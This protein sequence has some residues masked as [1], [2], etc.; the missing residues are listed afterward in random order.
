MTPHE[1]AWE[2][3]SLALEDLYVARA[4]A[5]DPN[6]PDRAVGYNLQQAVEKLLKALLAELNLDYPR[7]HSLRRLTGL[8]TEHG[9]TLPGFVQELGFLTRYAVVERYTIRPSPTLDRAKVLSLV[10][11]LRDWVENELA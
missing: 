5:P 1:H 9:Y 3:V 8:V 10:E 4:I 11:Q 7:T 2:L 6:L